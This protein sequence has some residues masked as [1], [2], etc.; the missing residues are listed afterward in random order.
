MEGWA[1]ALLHIGWTWDC[2]TDLA[3]MM[4]VEEQQRKE[5]LEKS[6]RVYRAASKRLQGIK[7]SKSK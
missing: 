5:G 7:R 3:S 2:G 4:W 1:A 6:N